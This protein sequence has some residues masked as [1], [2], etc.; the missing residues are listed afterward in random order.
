MTIDSAQTL[1]KV[2][3]PSLMSGTEGNVRFG[4]IVRLPFFSKYRFDMTYWLRWL[5]W[6]HMG[7][8]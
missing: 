6:G 8:G 1:A 7:D 2:S 5:L 4:F 3:S